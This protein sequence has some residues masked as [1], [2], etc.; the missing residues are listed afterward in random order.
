MAPFKTLVLDLDS[1]IYPADTALTT[2][3]DARTTA[4]LQRNSGLTTA[5][6]AVLEAERPSILDAL[7]KLG[8]PRRR[9]AESV[10][11]DLPYTQVLH[12]HP[13]LQSALARCQTRRVVVTLAPSAHA[14]SVLA[15]LGV[16][17]LIDDLHSVFDSADSVKD[18]IY[19]ALFANDVDPKQSVVIGDNPLLDLEPAAALGCRC[20]LV[21]QPR[22]SQPYPTF[23]SLLDALTHISAW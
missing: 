23:A 18:G 20:L 21:G 10:Y 2:L 11:T 1:T 8:I 17:E 3:I 14:A 4:F 16:A 6:L 7:D 9:W 13:E 5:E 15:A 19:G 12:P 22:V